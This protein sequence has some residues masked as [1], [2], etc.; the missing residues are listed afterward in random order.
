MWN[1]RK[2]GDIFPCWQTISA[3]KDEAG[4]VSHYVSLISDITTIKE[5]QAKAEYL[6]HHDPLTKLPNRL[7]FNARVD[8]AIE[9]AHRKGIMF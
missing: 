2:N 6:A 8:H 3:V 1:R 7:L 9:R 5:S 4:K